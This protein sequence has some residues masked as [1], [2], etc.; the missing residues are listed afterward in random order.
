MKNEAGEMVPYSS[1]VTI[2]ETQGL[3]E[4]TRFN[5][6]PTATIQG[7]PADGYTSDQ[8]IQAIRE[9]AAET[10][11]RGYGIA[12]AGLS[13]DQSRKGNQTVYVFVIVVTF[14]Y[15]VLSAQYESFLIPLAVMLSLP[16]G[17]FGSFYFLKA[18]GLENNV[19]AQ[20]GLIMLV[21]LL[22]KNAILI[23]EFAVQRRHS[24]LSFHE[25]AV[26]GGKT[27]FRPILMTSFA[28]IAALI[29]MVLAKGAGAIANQT[30]G[31][32]AAGGMLIGTVIGVLA[33]PGLYYI[34]GTLA[35]DSKLLQDESSK[36]L[37]ELFGDKKR[38][39]PLPEV[40]AGEI[41]E[42]LKHLHGSGGPS[43]LSQ[44]AIE[45]H[46]EF[47]RVVI[48]AKAAEL[49]DLTIVEQ[50]QVALNDEGIRFIEASPAER[51]TIWREHILRMQLFRQTQKA[52][53]AAG[54]QMDRDF[55][56][57]TIVLQLPR[58]DYEKTFATFVDWASYGDLFTYDDS[59]GQISENGQSES[60]PGEEA[61]PESPLGDG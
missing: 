24:G 7:A 23:V 54:G 29:P 38:F 14:V 2:K 57:E 45:T 30:I 56:I 59:T 3:N 60:R 34:F 16:I 61:P 26:E 53:R 58:A 50:H 36:P 4:M 32:T 49:L 46:G 40:T 20:I 44:I 37:T 33:I 47:G 15:F 28:F 11:P 21:G 18:M 12:W 35:G 9:V 19:Y 42:L 27:R 5:L 1:F 55:V 41:V 22:G 48:A 10:L 39:H 8:A 17:V 13:Y 31:T 51:Q 43:D 25:A 52:V 6:Y